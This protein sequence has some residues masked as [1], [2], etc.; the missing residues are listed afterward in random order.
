M[1]NQPERVEYTG[2]PGSEE[3][4]ASELVGIPEW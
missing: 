2:L 3:R 1:K 4:L